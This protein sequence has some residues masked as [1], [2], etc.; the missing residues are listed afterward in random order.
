MMRKFIM[1]MFLM[2]LQL[3]CIGKA[4]CITP[5]NLFP[6]SPN[7]YWQYQY[8]IDTQRTD[9]ISISGSKMINAVQTYNLVGTNSIWS[10]IEHTYLT[11]DA[12]GLRIHGEY[13]TEEYE[14][15]PNDWSDIDATYSPPIIVL[16]PTLTIGGTATSSG[17]V[18]VNV[19]GLDRNYSLS[20]NAS[21]KAV[22]Y[23]TITVPGGTYTALKVIISRTVTG[24]IEGGKI[25]DNQNRTLWLV[26]GK[27]LIRVNEYRDNVFQ[28]DLKLISTNVQPSPAPIC[29]L[30]GALTIPDYDTDGAYK[31]SWVT[32]ATSRVNYI[33]E[34]A[35]NAI[36]TTGRRIAYRGTLLSAAIKGRTKGITYYY[37]VK[38]TKTGFTE[39]NWQDGSIGCIV[40]L[41]NLP[42]LT[43]Y[44]PSAWSDKLVISKAT[45]SST[46]SAVLTKTDTLFV[47]WAVANIGNASTPSKYYI[48][49]YVDKILKKKWERTSLLPINYYTSEQDFSIGILSAGVHTIKIVAD[50]TGLLRESDESD[51]TFS[52]TIVVQ[53]TAPLPFIGTWSGT[54]EKKDGNDTY[55]NT[56]NSLIISAN[57]TWSANL[58][59]TMVVYGGVYSDN[60]SYS[61][62]YTMSGNKIIGTGS[63]SFEFIIG[64][65]GSNIAEG[66]YSNGLFSIKSTE[67]ST[68]LLS[69]Q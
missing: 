23:E 19:I 46:D 50:A 4:F 2:S 33:L 12:N 26:E 69:K 60:R 63:S 18:N 57:G 44:R 1:V 68:F 25:N 39:S 54:L 53:K 7:N 31:V 41:S 45:G 64:S 8:G 61:G 17:K 6:L 5:F 48:S 43:P 62:T 67:A 24:T 10:G 36:F 14:I 65:N 20:Y 47:D 51:N 3:L 29:D 66:T 21:S 35:T 15:Q 49:L 9:T 58:R 22:G 38:A 55:K 42:N 16:P 37:R 59:L 30:P 27:G 13:L 40:G 52:K 11:N 56:I 34:E 32:S 28:S